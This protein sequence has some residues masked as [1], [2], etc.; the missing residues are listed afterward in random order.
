MGIALFDT[1]G[2]ACDVDGEQARPV[3]VEERGEGVAQEGIDPGGEGGRDVDVA[4]P[5]SHDASVPGLDEGVVVR[6]PSAGLGEGA[7]VE[8]GE[9]LGDAMV[10]VFRSVVGV[11]GLDGDGKGGDEGFEE[12]DIGDRGEALEA[13]VAV[14]G[15]VVMAPQDLH[16][17]RAGELTVGLVDLGQERDVP[18]CSGEGKALRGAFPDGHGCRGSGG[19]DR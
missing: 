10:D 12:G 15:V 18:G 6:A 8:L 16:G 11:A 9:E 13:L 1:A 5:L 3:E 2:G 4:E 14:D 17:G 19:A 7:D